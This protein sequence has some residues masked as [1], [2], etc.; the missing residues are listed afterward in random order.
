M[1]DN[2]MSN[3]CKYAQPSSRVYVNLEKENDVVTITFR[4]I[5]KYQLNINGDELLERFIRGDSSRNTEGH[6]SREVTVDGDLFKVRLN[7]KLQEGAEE[8]LR[9]REENNEVQQENEK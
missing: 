8:L 4:N 3:I 9:Q 1:V 6:G 2:L 7:F 5:S